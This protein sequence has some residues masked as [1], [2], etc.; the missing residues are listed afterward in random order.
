MYSAYTMLWRCMC[1]SDHSHSLSPNNLGYTYSGCSVVQL[2]VLFVDVFRRFC[3]LF[4]FVSI[5][6]LLS[7]LVCVGSSSSWL[8]N[9]GPNRMCSLVQWSKAIEQAKY[10]CKAFR[11][12]ESKSNSVCWVH[13]WY[14]D[15]AL[16]S[17][18]SWNTGVSICRTWHFIHSIRVCMR[19]VRLSV[20]IML[21]IRLR[22]S[23]HFHCI[24]SSCCLFWICICCIEF[25]R[26]FILFMNCFHARLSIM[27][28]I[29]SIEIVRSAF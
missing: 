23:Q 18:G 5:M 19:H 25:V 4:L 14:R 11:Q 8:R 29:S 28:L 2:K 15:G 6:R 27:T 3:F 12:F 26:A 17:V 10:K 24:F 22:I 9:H 16:A 7:I 20:V 1:A 13:S 21:R